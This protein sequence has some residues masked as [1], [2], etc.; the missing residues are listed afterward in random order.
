MGADLTLVERFDNE[1]TSTGCCV[2]RLHGGSRLPATMWGFGPSKEHK[3]VENHLD[4]MALGLLI[5][6]CGSAV[7]I[8]E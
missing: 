7:V 1:L 3:L 2:L 4:G 5:N 6:S 8:S